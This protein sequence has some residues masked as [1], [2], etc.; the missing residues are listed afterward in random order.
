[1]LNANKA[2]RHNPYGD[3]YRIRGWMKYELGD[4]FAAITDCDEA[5]RLEP[6]NARAYYYRGLAKQD[7]G[8]HSPG[9]KDLEQALRLRGRSG[10][11]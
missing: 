6:D 1:M 2:I 8:H 3:L 11:P 4:H 9:R 5:I 7:L 10:R